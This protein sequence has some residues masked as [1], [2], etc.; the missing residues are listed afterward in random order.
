MHRSFS[1]CSSILREVRQLTQSSPQV[2]KRLL[3]HFYANNLQISFRKISYILWWNLKATHFFQ[4][5]FTEGS[6]RWNTNLQETAL[7]KVLINR[8]KKNLH[9]LSVLMQ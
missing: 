7:E 1:Y 3:Q 9:F 5:P 8:F 4:N 2:N 6:V